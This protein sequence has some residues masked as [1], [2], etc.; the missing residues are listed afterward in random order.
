VLSLVVSLLLSGGFLGGLGDF[1]GT[2]LALLHRL[3]DADGDRLPHVADGKA[4]EW[5]VFGKRLHAHR[6]LRHHLDYRGVAGLDEAR[7]VLELLAATAIYLLEQLAELARDVRRVAVEH[8]RVAGVDL[9]GM[10]QDDNLH[11]YTPHYHG[12][13]N[14]EV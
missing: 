9:T 1:A 13:Q 12:L 5:S 6:L 4:A 2:P 10:V 14:A 3:D 8:R 11:T 7:V